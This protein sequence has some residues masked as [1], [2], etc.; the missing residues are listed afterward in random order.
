MIQ[1]SIQSISTSLYKFQQ[2]SRLKFVEICSAKFTEICR[3]W[4]VI[5]IFLTLHFNCFAQS[6]S[7]AELINNAKQYDAKTVTYE[8]EVI[9][10]IMKRGDFAWINVHDGKNAVGIWL[11]AA[12]TKEIIYTGSYQAIGDSVEV[13]GIFHRACPEHG[14]DLDIHAQSLRK[15]APG[16]LL[17]KKLNLNKRNYIFGLLALLIFIWILTRLKAK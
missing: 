4:F 16:R 10:E 13:E 1:K 9:G 2:V 3:L 7:S 12:L 11:D 14:G 15:V 17:T 6:I 8:G 5:F